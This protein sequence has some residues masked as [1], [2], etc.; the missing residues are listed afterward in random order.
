MS[1]AVTISL[2]NILWAQWSKCLSEKKTSWQSS[3]F[4][5]MLRSSFSVEL[6]FCP[7]AVEYTIKDILVC[8]MLYFFGSKLQL[9]SISYGKV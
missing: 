6:Y 2:K 5:H 9:T 7:G 8:C 4:S 3:D 1:E